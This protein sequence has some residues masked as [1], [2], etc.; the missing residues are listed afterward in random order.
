MKRIVLL[1]LS[2]TLVLC[3]GAAPALADSVQTVTAAGSATVTVTP[4]MATFTVGV[5]TQDTLVTTAQTENAAAMQA[6]VS[7][8]KGLGVADKDLQTDNYS[9]SPTYNYQDDG[10]QVLTGYVV[11]NTVEVTVRDLTQLP[12]LLDKSVAAG[13][14]QTYGITFT[15]S[16]CDDAYDQA[17]TAAVQ[18][19]L[20]K[21][22][23]M[24]GSLGLTTGSVLSLTEGSNTYV[25]TYA[26]RSTNYEL[27]A[28]TPIESGSLTVSANVTA[29]VE[30]K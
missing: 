12:E 29:V 11:S 7:A 1:L 14:N 13:A 24:A 4:D 19:A 17:L 23:L 30:M 8:L 25:T 5:S 6:V 3:L 28:A 16:A 15:S 21:A 20:S 10:T 26:S 22:S 27:D 9:V 18:D 2:L